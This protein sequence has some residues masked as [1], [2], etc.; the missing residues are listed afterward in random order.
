MTGNF[1]KLS[2]NFATKFRFM[3]RTFVSVPEISLNFRLKRKF[4]I[5][6]P[7]I[8]K[9]AEFRQSLLLFFL[10][11]TVFCWLSYPPEIWRSRLALIRFTAENASLFCL[12]YEMSKKAKNHKKLWRNLCIVSETLYLDAEYYYYSLFEEKYIYTRVT[13]P[14]KRVIVGNRLW[15]FITNWRNRQL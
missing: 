4:A 1:V 12:S 11:S 5:C 6:S 2:L 7:K 13:L 9:F 8:A 10:H 14:C 15:R 3:P